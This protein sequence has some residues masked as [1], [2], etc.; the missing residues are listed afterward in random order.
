MRAETPEQCWPRRV[1][2]RNLVPQTQREMTWG[3]RAPL[4][5]ETVVQRSAEKKAAQRSDANGVLQ[6]KLLASHF[7]EKVCCQLLFVVIFLS[8]V[9]LRELYRWKTEPGHSTDRAQTSNSLTKA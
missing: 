6:Q 5:K 2:Y 3:W 4:G 7:R 1:G 9:N 8:P